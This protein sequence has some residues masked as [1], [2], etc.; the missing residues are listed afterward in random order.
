M[1]ADKAGQYEVNN[2]SRGSE[3]HMEESTDGVPVIENPNR[4]TR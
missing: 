2:E 3:E 1:A 4:K